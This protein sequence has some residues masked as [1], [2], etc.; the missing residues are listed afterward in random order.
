MKIAAILVL[1]AWAA[2]VLFCSLLLAK[3]EEPWTEG[4]DLEVTDYTTNTVKSKN[5]D[6]VKKFLEDGR[7]KGWPHDPYIRPTGDI[8]RTPAGKIV[9]GM[10]HHRVRIYY[11]PAVVD[12]LGVRQRVGPIADRAM[13]VKEMYQSIPPIYPDKD[14]VIGWAAMVKKTGASHGGWYWVIYFKPEFRTMATMGEFSYSFCLTCHASTKNENT[15]SAV[16]N[17]SGENAANDTGQS[18]IE[19][20]DP[21]FFKSLASMAAEGG[22]EPNKQIDATFDTTYS[23]SH[24]YPYTDVPKYKAQESGPAFPLTAY[25]HVWNPAQ[26]T[27]EK[28]YITSDNCS[29]CHD[30]TDLVET[31]V[32]NML[33]RRWTDDTETG[34]KGYELLN[35]SVYGEWRASPMGMAGRDPIFFSQLE[36]EL[37][38][39]DD[40]Y[41]E[42]IQNTCLTCHGAMGQKQF[43]VEQGEDK[44]FLLDDVFVT[45]GKGARY[46]AL[47]RDGISCLICHQMSPDNFHASKLPNTG[48]FEQGTWNDI[49]G[50]TSPTADP[51]GPIRPYPMQ[52]ALG[53]TPKYDPYLQK[54]ELCGTC[55]VIV[56]PVYEGEEK[57]RSH[58]PVTDDGDDALL[59]EAHEQDTYLEWLYSAYQGGKDEATAQ[60]CQDCHMRSTF[61]GNDD[62]MAARVANVQNTSWPIPPAQ[63][64]APAEEITVPTRKD[65]KRHTFF[66]MNLFVLNMYRQ[67][68][69]VLGLSS[70]S[71][72]PMGT[73]N[74]YDFA[75]ENGEWQIRNRTA[76]VEVLDVT[77]DED[78]LVARVRVTNKAGHRLPSG[79][80]F[81]R[82][83]LE[84]AVLDGQK[85]PNVLWASGLT[86]SQGVILGAPVARPGGPI[87]AR[88]ESE[89]T[90]NWEKIQPHWETIMSQDHVQIYEERYINRY[91]KK[92]EMRLTTSFLGIGE[93]VK[94]NRLQPR[95]YYFAYI[96]EQR[97][98]AKTAE[99]REKW[100]SLL[101]T[102]RL[103]GGSDPMKDPDYTSG[104]GADV[105]T[106]RIP[107]SEIPGAAVVRARLNYQ[108]I[109]PY[110]LRDRFSYGRGPQ[111]QRLYYIV[112]H[113]KTKG[114]AIE[115]WKI[116]IAEGTGL[117]PQP[118]R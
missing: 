45:E 17:L 68:G 116:R 92:K 39:H 106:Y 57:F 2:T 87:R 15:F 100:D 51:G 33:I 117:V 7:Y 115:D 74:L 10:T 3:P 98:K 103:V 101:P 4:P 19:V 27:Y 50:P 102:S 37:N 109:P 8:Y 25:D 31:Q 64:L 32:P 44:D 82:A 93:V 21:L 49:Y 104:S 62:P 5:L 46:G 110:W 53:A 26:P 20:A 58:N 47:A 85:E 69:K 16:T 18:I 60:S 12:W 41:A 36:S 105:V 34:N 114:T 78:D 107:L 79:V 70:D 84:F 66:G 1:G 72:P 63:H 40:K 42:T 96:K 52:Q 81:R 111:T 90:G 99:E 6:T 24:I 73:T 28:S 54:S 14:P 55:H 43:H 30:A 67:F 88:L 80:G 113:M 22:P 35:L 65:F 89:F 75:I 94:S 95:G 71:N 38:M 118:P 76:S 112:G 83:W 91:G 61:Q 59:S 97:E 29:G 77:R 56:L 23:N 13:I 108:N 9:D 48:E 86:D 11:S